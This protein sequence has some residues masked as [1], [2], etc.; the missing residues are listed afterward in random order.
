MSNEHVQAE[1]K[2][3]VEGRSSACD[4]TEKSI[5][6]MLHGW[7][8]NANVFRHQVKTLTKKLNK[9][10][11]DCLFLAAPITLPPIDDNTLMPLPIASD[12]LERKKGRNNARAWFLYTPDDPSD[13]FFWKSGRKIEYVGLVESLRFLQEELQ[14]VP[15]NIRRV[16]LLGFSQGAVFT[17]II[18]SLAVSRG[19]P[20]NR[21][22]SFIFVGGFSASPLQWSLEDLSNL[23][24]PSLHV[25]GSSDTSVPSALGRRLAGRF[26]N[27]IILEHDKGHVV[28]QQAKACS[29]MINFI[30][31]TETDSVA[32]E[33][34]TKQVMM[35]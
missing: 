4:D 24:I 13:Q 34:L 8:Q 30:Q 20:W 35:R 21:I 12:N 17:H 3:W 32:T 16:S 5:V 27:A 33:E 10:G 1:A 19:S 26:Q 7:A 9:Q 29:T 22:Q 14:K 11:V 23:S 15:A 28:P 6:I 31:G 18:A 25:I 2:I